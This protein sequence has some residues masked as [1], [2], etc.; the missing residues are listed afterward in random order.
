MMGVIFLIWLF[1]APHNAYYAACKLRRGFGGIRRALVAFINKN[2]LAVAGVE[3]ADASLDDFLAESAG[4]MRNENLSSV[5]S[6]IFPTLGI[7]GTFISIAISMPDFSAQTSEV[8][9]QEI[10]RLLGGVGTAFYV[11]IYGIFLS[12]WWIFFEKSGISR[13]E[14]DVAELRKVTRPFFWEKKEIEQTYYRKSLAHFEKLDTLY[15]MMASRDFVAE[16]NRTLEQRLHIFGQIIEREQQ[17]AEAHGKLMAQSGSLF[18]R[19]AKEQTASAEALQHVGL[20]LERFA[21]QMREE[22]ERMEQRRQTLSREYQ[23]GVT[24]AETL[25]GEIARLSEALANLNAGNVKEL[26]S[27]VLANIESMKREIDRVGVQFDEH[28]R[29]FD[30][31]F[32]EKLQRTLKLIDS[33]TAQ[34]VKQIARLNKSDGETR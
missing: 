14:R 7:L 1:F 9:E 6:G 18:D 19:L 31:Q 5:A 8:L 33:E 21:A 2:I 3:K 30:A 23:R 32:L 20:G 26:Y 22:D 24:V 34:I 10:S 27:G 16:V 4:M 12:I 28:I 13:F 17:A 15:D 25:G 11:S 29:G